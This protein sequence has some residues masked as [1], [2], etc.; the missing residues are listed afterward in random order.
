ML[1][2]ISSVAAQTIDRSIRPTAAPATEIQIKD[3]KTFTLPNG[4]K[5]FV[6]E[7][8]K[9]P[10]VYFSLSLDIFP[11]LE[12][13]KAGLESL[14]SSVLGTATKKRSK[15][16]INTSVDLIGATFG[17]HSRGGYIASLSKYQ[18]KALDILSDALINPV[19]KQE[20]LDLNVTREKT[21]L[22]TIGDDGSSISNRVT[23]ALLFGKN[24]P[25]G[26]ITT[27]ESLDNV[28]LADLQKF[29]ATYF[30]PNVARLV[31]VGDITEEQAKKYATKY[32]G[33]WKNKNVPQ[34]Q[35]PTV[36]A[37]QGNKVAMV[38][39]DGAMQSYINVTY[40]IDYKVG[41]SDYIAAGLADHF[42]G[43]GMSS[44]LFQILRE[45]HSYTY[46]VYSDLSSDRICGKFQITA[47]RGDAASVK[48]AATDS[49]IVEI[50]AAMRE[51]ISKPVSDEQ[52]AAAKA[53]FAGSF[54]RSLEHSSTIANF[55]TNIDRYNL[56]KDYYKT[57]LQRLDAVTAADVQAAAKKYFHPDNALITVVGDKSLAAKM[58]K[59]AS[60]NSVQFYD[61]NANPVEAPTTKSAD[62]SAEQI[63]A[64]YA[65]AL[66]GE[67]A[68]AKVND[69]KIVSNMNMMGQILEMVE[70]FKKPN[71]T[72]TTISMGQMLVQKLAFDG[73]ALKKSGMQGDATLTEGQEFE[74]AKA[75]AG[76]CAEMNLIKNGY[77]LTVKGIEN[78]NGKDA[79]GL[80]ISKG[81]EQ[82]N[83][84]FDVETGLKIKTIL[85]SET[86]QGTMQ[87][88]TEYS[89]YKAVDGIMFPHAIKQSAGGITID[90]SVKSIEVNKGLDDALFQ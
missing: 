47:G 35:Y 16:Q 23:S 21:A 33:K 86:P 26:E 52:L 17:V 14:T 74:A 71:N 64:N 88:I 67:N 39:K 72:L 9:R 73:N 6:V 3:A 55:A 59:F 10:V 25:Y 84:Y 12:G 1:L 29:H 15:E 30:A 7:D 36:A 5:V 82:S 89:D 41:M 62:I 31:I 28:N 44:M 45:K 48:G 18:T 42:Y 83:S 24:H 32:F 57:Y 22:A 61:M 19:F 51:M 46:G 54:G 2:I 79:Y 43:G 66:G 58:E 40:P 38:N 34:T 68:L 70:A 69:Y 80:E 75:E 4:L 53:T 77:Q 81:K 76:L 37:P 49:A 78:L 60:D 8:H 85:T 63:I 11:A 90:V 65:K 87:Q 50:F 27:E 56:P 13:D 20:E